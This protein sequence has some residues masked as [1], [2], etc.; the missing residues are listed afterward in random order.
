[1]VSEFFRSMDSGNVRID[2]HSA[3]ALFFKSFE[4]LASG[5]IELAG[6][7]Y[8]QGPAAK[9]QN[10]LDLPIHGRAHLEMSQRRRTPLWVLD[11][12]PGGIARKRSVALDAASPHLCHHLR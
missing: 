8:L 7:A 9:Q 10:F 5:V 2:Q 3:N 12:L 11:S 4:S 1:M 6:L